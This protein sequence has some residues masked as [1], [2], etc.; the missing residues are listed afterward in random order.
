M[1]I[2]L[3]VSTVHY[4][5]VKEMSGSTA[6]ACVVLVTGPNM[7]GKSTLMR[8]VGCIVILAQLV[9]LMILKYYKYTLLVDTENFILLKTS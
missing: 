4:V 5:D 1:S 8:Q 9:S 2:L 7:G 6:E 3:V